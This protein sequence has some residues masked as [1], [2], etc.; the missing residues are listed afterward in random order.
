MTRNTDR[1]GFSLRPYQNE[2]I[3]SIRQT[4]KKED[5]QLIQ[6]PTGA[7]KTVVFWDY[8]S[9]Y[10]KSA[11]IVVPSVHLAE[12]V[13]EASKHFIHPSLLSA[14]IGRRRDVIIK[15]YHI[16]S[17]MGI[18]RQKSLDELN[19]HEFDV[20]VIDEAHKA[21][22]QN[23]E[24]TIP[25][26][27][28]VKKVLGVTATPYRTD[29]KSL[30]TI[31]KSLTYKKNLMELIKEGYLCDLKGIRIQTQIALV[32]DSKGSDFAATSLYKQL[33]KKARNDLIV[34]IYSKHCANKKTLIFCINIAHTEEIAHLLKGKGIKAQ[35]IHGKMPLNQRSQILK[36]FRDG[37]IEVL[38]NAQLLTEGF[39]E[40]SIEALIL[41]RP[42]K[43]RVLYMQMIGRG[44]RTYPG[45]KFC[46]VIDIADSYQLLCSFLSIP[47]PEEDLRG[48]NQP[49]DDLL[50]LKFIDD[51]MSTFEAKLKE[52]K[53]IYI[54]FK[55]MDSSSLL[56]NIPPTYL[57]EI[58]PEWSTWEEV[59][60][61]RWKEKMLKEFEIWV[62]LEKA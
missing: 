8:I 9:K 35:A 37:K 51:N 61:L 40:P 36:D 23:F 25:K 54:D 7:G 19:Q 14:K 52:Y 48:T 31:F 57:S 4:F 18:L 29:Q 49:H 45:K 26:L 34:E 60:F 39:D 10:C 17:S 58:S 62:Q 5:F 2:C 15:P 16:V 56:E 44:T 28:C 43:S 47:F 27:T 13:E 46:I 30:L 42:T 32:N 38:T 50:S 6:L 1:E 12:Q 53:E 11:L 41:A 33:N 3:S 59:L 21:R 55:E 24:R 22:A 20:M